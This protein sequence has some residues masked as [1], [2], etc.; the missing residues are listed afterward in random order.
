MSWHLSSIGIGTYLGDST[1]EEDERYATVV[2][3]AL[4][5]G[6]NVVDS[7]IN[8]RC[9]RSE[10]AV[11][12]ALERAIADGV[13]RRDEVVLSSKG[14]FVPLDGSPPTKRSDY[15]DYLRREFFE[16]GVMGPEDVDASGHC[17]APGFLRYCIAHSR[18]NLGV[19]TIDI[20]YLH[21]P[22][23]QLAAVS[24]SSFRERMRAA[25]MVFED[26]VSRGEIGVY[27]CATWT[28]LRVAPKT[29]GHLDLVALEQIAREIA[30]DS[31]HFRAVQ[32]PINL[33]MTEAVR[34]PTQRRRGDGAAATLLEVA[35]DLDVAVMASAS[36]MQGQLTHGLP[37]PVRELFPSLETDAQRALNF[38]RSLPS[39]T[40]ALVGMKTVEHLEENLGAGRRR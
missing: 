31:H 13:V 37:D 39:L 17:M 6:I 38:V 26:A 5:S 4:E 16:A 25:F 36:L 3:R 27:G 21:N 34:A 24:P 19:S 7:A 10:R 33:A 40:S 14:G 2:R 9:Q 28:G 12:A 18:R 8:Y 11:G 30:G 20:Y 15:V 29:R 1:A 32:L 35:A 22:E 23:Q